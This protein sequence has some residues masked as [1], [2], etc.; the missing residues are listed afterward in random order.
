MNVVEQLSAFA[1]LLDFLLGVTCGVFGS[2]IFGSVRENRDMSL[3]REASDPVSAGAREFFGLF[4]RDDGGYLR[5]LTPGAH[6]APRGAHRDDSS[7]SRGQ[8]TER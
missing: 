1:L 2:A 8:G 7:G 4:T 3:L 5:S 6:P